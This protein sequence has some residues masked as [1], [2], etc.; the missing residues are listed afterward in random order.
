MGTLALILV[1][2]AIFI[3]G[4]AGLLAYRRHRA[5]ETVPSAGFRLGGTATWVAL[6][7]VLFLVGVLVFPRL[8][9]FT[10][11]FLPLIWVRAL[12]RRRPHDEDR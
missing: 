8:L 4:A 7:A 12:G 1:P 9:G 5:W 10:F 2:A 11:L 6:S 3:V